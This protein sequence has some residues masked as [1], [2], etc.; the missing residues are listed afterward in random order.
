M[1]GSRFKSAGPTGPGKYSELSVGRVKFGDMSLSCFADT[2]EG[3]C[4]RGDDGCEDWFMVETKGHAVWC[5]LLR[6]DVHI[7]FKRQTA[8]PER[9][10]WSS[11][12]LT[13]FLLDSILVPPGFLH[14]SREQNLSVS[15]HN[16]IRPGKDPNLLYTNVQLEIGQTGRRLHELVI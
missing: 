5:A 4:E 6:V 16:P 12:P 9:W 14:A 10:K 11:I 7:Y 3:A 13:F 15:Q 8:V 2:R 1:G